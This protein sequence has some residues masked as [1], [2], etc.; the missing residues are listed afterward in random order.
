MS[1]LSLWI[2]D[3]AER[4][5]VYHKRILAQWDHQHPNR[6]LIIQGRLRNS[7][8]QQSSAAREAVEA[9]LGPHP[10]ANEGGL[11]DIVLTQE[12][13]AKLGMA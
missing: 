10:N 8:M 3:P 9:R 1:F 12:E 2:H 13:K 11:D 4:D 5:I 6:Q 7:A